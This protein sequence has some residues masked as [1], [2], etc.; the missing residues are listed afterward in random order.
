MSSKLENLLADAHRGDADSQYELGWM[1]AN[2]KGV[3][4]NHKEAATWLIKAAEKN[5]TSAQFYIGFMYEN[6]LGVRKNFKEAA[7]WY[8]KA[9]SHD[10]SKVNEN[11]FRAELYPI[12]IHKAQFH[13]GFMYENGKGVLK[14][15]KKALNSYKKALGLLENLD[16]WDW[17]IKTEGYE[18]ADLHED[19]SKWFITLYPEDQSFPEDNIF[20][21]LASTFHNLGMKYYRGEGVLKDN[22][23]ALSFFWEGYWLGC[24]LHSAYMLHILDPE[25]GFA[26]DDHEIWET[27]MSLL[28]VSAGSEVF[29]NVNSM[30]SHYYWDMYE[31]KPDLSDI[32]LYKKAVRKGLAKS[33][34]LLGTIYGENVIRTNKNAVI[35]EATRKS[36]SK[37]WIIKAYENSD[38]DI[39]EKAVNFWNTHELWKYED[40]IDVK[41]EPTD[42]EK[43]KNIISIDNKSEESSLTGIFGGSAFISIGRRFINGDGILKDPIKAIKYYKKAIEH[44]N[45]TKNQRDLMDAKAKF[46]LGVIYHEENSVK[47]YA[48]S[49]YWIN[50]AYESS[51]TIISKNA[52]DFWNKNKLWN[53]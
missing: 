7:K 41:N 34:Y 49:K 16:P 43:I 28:D 30:S 46:E 24:D 19:A 40:H 3:P 10:H 13:L 32:E 11:K 4:S 42:D 36:L 29:I 27:D 45:V 31:K 12:N 21:T 47:D 52:E 33:Q 26:D 6:G 5:N 51:V 22:E 2:G 38:R 39:R 20:L 1:F 15:H 23:K 48:E 18:G 44:S 8:K 17:Y 35:P 50:K 14:D 25:H 37:Y 53:Y 9:A